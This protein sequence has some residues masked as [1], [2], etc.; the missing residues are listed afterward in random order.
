MGSIPY[1]YLDGFS[2]L[3]ISFQPSNL[4]HT[5]LCVLPP[6]GSGECLQMATVGGLA[7]VGL[8]GYVLAGRAEEALAKWGAVNR[9]WE[10]FKFQDLACHYSYLGNLLEGVSHS[11]NYTSLLDGEISHL[12]NVAAR[13]RTGRLVGPE[14]ALKGFT[15][16]YSTM[17]SNPHRVEYKRIFHCCLALFEVRLRGIQGHPERSV[18][19]EVVEQFLGWVAT[20]DQWQRDEVVRTRAVYSTQTGVVFRARNPGM[21]TNRMVSIHPI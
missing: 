16:M 15:Q 1:L 3:L 7:G 10:K 20:L 8:Q 19:Y 12:R 13:V 17:R 14:S 11:S 9:V 6:R 2:S 5:L 21:E 18:Q 4:A